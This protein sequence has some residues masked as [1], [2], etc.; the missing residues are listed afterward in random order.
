MVFIIPTQPVMQFA[1]ERPI[2]QLCLK[3]W[4]G[5]GASTLYEDDGERVLS[6]DRELG[7][8]QRI[9]QRSGDRSDCREVGGALAG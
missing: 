4:A 2:E 5:N 1:G 8:P 3:V 6:F 7:Q 9:E